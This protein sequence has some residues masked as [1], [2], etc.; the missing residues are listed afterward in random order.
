MNP[1]RLDRFKK[2]ALTSI[3]ETHGCISILTAF[4]T[5]VTVSIAGSA[6]GSPLKVANDASNPESKTA[7]DASITKK[8][9]KVIEDL[10]NFHEVHSYL[11]RGGEPTEAGLDK[12]K[13]MG[14][15]TIIDLRSPGERAFKEPDV[16]KEKGLRYIHMLMSSKAPTKQQVKTL[17]D[18][19]DK[20]K[21]KNE[22]LF[23]HCAHGSDRTGCM[24]GIVRVA[25]DDWSFDDTYKEMRKYW[26]GQKYTELRNAVKE[27]STH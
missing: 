21:A 22:P 15:K 4:A 7:Q 10:P 24:V 18:E 9:N 26:F 5:F 19:V 2:T 11:Y 25:R 14:V 3:R 20:A 1:A 12:L 17:L 8:R 6:Y 27:R 13:E 16:A 23:V